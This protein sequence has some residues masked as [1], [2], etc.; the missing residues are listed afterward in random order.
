M[1]LKFLQ[2]IMLMNSIITNQNL[3]TLRLRRGLFFL[4]PGNR[5]IACSS[6]Q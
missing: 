6:K 1:L 3:T 5:V 2:I 4:F